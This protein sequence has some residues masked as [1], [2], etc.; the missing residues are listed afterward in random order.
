MDEYFETNQDLPEHRLRAG[1]VGLWTGYRLGDNLWV[2]FPVRWRLK[3]F[4]IDVQF[5]YTAEA[6]LDW[7][8]EPV[9]L[10]K[11]GVE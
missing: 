4:W 3:G 11:E 7:F 5:L 10:A 6:P 8:A 1:A 2:V 9:L